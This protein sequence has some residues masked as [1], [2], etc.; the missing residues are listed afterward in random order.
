MKKVNIRELARKTAGPFVS[1]YM[2]THKTFPDNR[3]DPI[4]FKNLI[5]M[6]A[7]KLKAEKLDLEVFFSEVQS[8]SNDVEFWNN[9]TDGLAILIDTEDTYLC[10]LNGRVNEKVFVSD[11]FYL[12]PLINYYELPDE[13]LFLDLSKDRFSLYSYK[14]GT[15][16]QKNPEIYDRFTEL[17]P[18]RD[19]GAV[20][21]VPIGGR[22]GAVYDHT[23]VVDVKERD[24]EKYYR[25][26]NRELKVFLQE[27][28]AKLIL[29][30]TTENVTEF[31][32]MADFEIY[33]IIDK[34]FDSVDNLTLYDV[35]K[36]EL[37]PKYVKQ[38]EERLEGLRIE[39]AQ[40]H[41]T[42]NRSR[43]ERDVK[44]GK[45]DTLFIARDIEESDEL[46][47]LIN[48]V[49]TMGGDVIIVNREYN[50]FNEKTAAKYRY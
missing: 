4:R 20:G 23:T 42:D 28:Q 22:S 21:S 19:L 35:L 41:G 48:T 46:D 30:G 32:N 5:N 49:L 36:E 31:Q 34:P 25:Y 8:L 14:E 27:K 43:I 38:M 29:F 17:F 12:L 40:G 3:Q 50:R 44:A 15:L 6:A 26:L 37:L 45:V 7:D 33:G 10:N 1:I 16:N 47:K 39:I 2:P 13:Y 18:D 9:R 11:H 24:R